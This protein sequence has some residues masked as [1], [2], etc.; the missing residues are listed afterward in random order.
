MRLLVLN[1]N[2]IG[3]GCGTVLI[4][5]ISRE[6]GPVWVGGWLGGLGGWVDGRVLLGKWVGGWWVDGGSTGLPVLAAAPA[7][8]VG[9][10][11]FLVR[12]EV[13]FFSFSSSFLFLLG[14]RGLLVE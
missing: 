11:P 5:S 1:G 4:C 13:F 9:V 10:C 2:F 14:G 3:V 12:E 6:A 8:Q 7:P